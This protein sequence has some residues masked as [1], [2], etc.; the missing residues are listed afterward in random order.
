MAEEQLNTSPTAPQAESSDEFDD[1]VKGPISGVDAVDFVN[2]ASDPDVVADIKKTIF[3]QIK[4]ARSNRNSKLSD[5][6]DRYRD[7][8]NQRR[9]ISF[10]E[11]R[12]RLFLGAIRKAVDTLTRIAKDSMLADPYVSVETDV[13]RWRDVGVHF[14]K[15]LLE[16]Q[17][18]IRPKLS[19]FLRQLYQIGT[20]CMKFGW[21]TSYRNIT[22]REKGELG[23]EIK[24]RK[25]YD[26]YGPTLDVIDMRH[27]Y[28]WPEVA[29]DYNGLQIV[30]EDSVTTIATLRRKV[31]EGWYEP[32]TVDKVIQKRSSEIAQDNK[33][34]SHAVKEGMVDGELEQGELD[35][36]EAWVRYRLP[37]DEGDSECL[38][39]VWLTFAGEEVLRIQE[40]PWWFQAPPYLFGAIFREHDYFYGHG[41]IEAT[42]MW[43]YMLNDIVNQTMDCGTYALNPITIMDPAAVDDPDMYQI[44]PM[45]KWMIAP[46]AVSFERPPANMTQEGLGMVR[47]LLNIVQEATDATAIVQ[48]T[49]REGMGPAAGTA[50]GISQL[51][52]SSSAAIVDQVEELE[53][54]VFT[55]LLKM[56]EIAAHQFM[57]EKMVI[58]LEGPDAAVITQRIIEPSDLILSTDVRWIAS[59]RLREKLAK[60]QQY[61]NMLNIALGVDPQMTLQQ[62][63]M[64]DLK[65]LIKGAAISIGADDAD[66]IIKDVTQG[67]P[68]IPAELEYELAISGRSVVASPLESVEDH[69]R[70]IQILMRLPLPQTEYAQI[71]LKE[72]IASHYAVLNQ[73]QAQMMAQQANGTPGGAQRGPVG[74]QM[75]GGGTPLRP[76]EQPQNAGPGD[77]LKGL[78]SQIG[79]A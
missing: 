31:K 63:F 18:Q 52:A 75:M 10:Y 5:D 2:F 49:P 13:E 68:G 26:H 24:K 11:G 57:D 47:F 59:R 35:I 79:G 16:N 1:T 4:K 44:E 46:D 74:G 60:G 67:L 15:Y 40:N 50:T 71:K 3:P 45:A 43:Q 25:A 17:G 28:V 14:I 69:V 78:L 39:W 9:T 36:T 27:V 48:G 32:E 62:G 42:E 66:K 33:S 8:Y 77:A 23:L 61:L 34:R 64:I 7:V 37:D 12:S 22:Y 38:P 20:S 58:R 56:V 72:L 65:Y 21:K 70:K 29:T 53:A 54:Q 30:F 55:P 6:W 76:Q 19:M 51:M 73:V 41:L